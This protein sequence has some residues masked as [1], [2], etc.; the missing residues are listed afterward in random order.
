MNAIT[1][2]MLLLAA[3]ACINTYRGKYGPEDYSTCRNI[4]K[5]DVKDVQFD[6]GYLS[7]GTLLIA[8]RGSSREDWKYNFRFMKKR[9]PYEG[10]NKKLL[11]HTGFIEE[12]L[13][14]R[15]IIHNEIRSM[16]SQDLKHVL[17]TGHSLG[18]ALTQLCAVD[19][20]Y[21]WRAL[22]IR[23][24]PIAAPR[25]GNRVFAQSYNMRVPAT[26][27]I[28]NQF[29]TVCKVPP[30]CFGY[31]HVGTEIVVGKQTWWWYILHPVLAL[32]GN[33]L[34]HY[35]QRY[36]EGIKEIEV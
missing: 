5:F 10:V 6:M 18:G 21:H 3:Q 25:V 32:F 29:D 12:Y 14:V 17:V 8:F 27:R 22:Q 20:Q 2:D 9:V 23:A 4:R 24:I 7:D 30:E 16:I 35:P 33:P 28:V 19:L 1:K 13:Q 11:V 26:V 31:E 15:D 36:L 34:D